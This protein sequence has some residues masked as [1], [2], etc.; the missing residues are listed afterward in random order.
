MVAVALFTRNQD[1][2]GDRAEQ[3]R[4]ALQISG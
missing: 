4:R 2:P 3:L 1:V